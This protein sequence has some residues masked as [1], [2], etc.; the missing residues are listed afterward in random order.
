MADDLRSVRTELAVLL[1]QSYRN[2]H[3]QTALHTHDPSEQ[4]SGCSMEEEVPILERAASKVVLFQL[5]P[6]RKAFAQLEVIRSL[7]RAFCRLWCYRY[8]S[9]VRTRQERQPQEMSRTRRGDKDLKMS[10]TIFNGIR[11]IAIFEFLLRYIEWM[12]SGTNIWITGLLH[13]TKFLKRRACD[14]FLAF[15]I[16]FSYTTLRYWPEYVNIFLSEHA[17]TTA[18]QDEVMK[19][20]NLKQCQQETEV[21]SEA[22]FNT[23]V[24]R[25]RI[26]IALQN[27]NPTFIIGLQSAFRNLVTHRTEKLEDTRGTFENFIQ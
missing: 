18:I 27:E 24:Y 14:H 8:Y 25:C 2:Q 15:K 17:T 10:M 16:A 3:P 9:L 20:N 11:L 26:K 6:R 7:H 4:S 21:D 12:R 22:P 23:T 1:N 13:N 19:L 5:K